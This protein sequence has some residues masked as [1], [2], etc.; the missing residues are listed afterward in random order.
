[1]LKKKLSAPSKPH[2]AN[3]LEAIKHRMALSNMADFYAQAHM[4]VV[5]Q[6]LTDAC[7][8]IDRIWE[9][10]DFISAEDARKRERASRKKAV[11]GLH[12]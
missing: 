12:S 8:E 2:L 10:D 4:P 11:V 3:V 7:Q 5:S 9:E 6:C 1:M